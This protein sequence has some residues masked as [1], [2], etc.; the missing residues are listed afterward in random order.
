MTSG[1]RC[2][3]RCYC[4]AIILMTATMTTLASDE[5]S[6]ANPTPPDPTFEKKLEAFDRRTATVQ[7]MSA[8]F[9]QRKY[10]TLL[11]KPLVS[12]G[13][14]KIKGNYSRW[15]THKPRP[16]T[17]V[18]SPTAI[19]VFY[20]K[21]SLLEVY[22]LD[23]KLRWAAISPAPQLAALREQ[24]KLTPM[25]IEKFDKRV[26]PTDSLCIRATPRG[27]TMRDYLDHID[28]LIDNATALIVA[29]IITDA[30]GDRT[31][32]IFSRMRTNT[33]MDDQEVTLNIPADT[34]IVHPLGRQQSQL[35]KQSSGDE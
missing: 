12:R 7:D 9:L 18:I 3:V 17:L 25:S 8:D 26:R 31:E 35:T 15:D 4:L 23:D 24:F 1:Q 33:G 10:T 16:S 13:K 22:E 32:L 14:L 2:V 28:I 34:K 19:S 5:S 6:K 21:Q 29:S 27:E 11:K 30:D 20:P